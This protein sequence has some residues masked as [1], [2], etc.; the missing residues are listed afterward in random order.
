VRQL[1]RSKDIAPEQVQG[2]IDWKRRNI[3]LMEKTR[4]YM[5]NPPNEA[6][7]LR[8]IIT[9]VYLAY[10]VK[11]A[12]MNASTMMNTYVAAT[13]AA[14]EVQGNKI[15]AR[16]MKDAGWLM[17]APEKYTTIEGVLDSGDARQL[18]LVTIME[19]AIQDGVLDQSYAYYLAG[20]A[21]QNLANA[22]AGKV[23]QGFHKTAEAGMYLFQ[24]MEKANRLVTLLS[25]YEV[26]KL[27]GATPT[28]AYEEA[29]RETNL[30]QNDYSAAN[31]PTLMR[32]KMALF[33][34]FQ[35]Y[36]Q[37]MTWV[38]TGGYERGARA[39]A[40]GAGRSYAPAYRGPTVKL[41]LM[42]LAL[43][44]YMGVPFAANIMDLL[45]VLY[46]KFTGGNL[47]ADV[48]EFFR[49]QSLDSNLVQHGLMHDFF[50]MDL[51][52]SLGLGRLFPGTDM[53]N[54]RS[55]SAPEFF[56]NLG[57]TLLGVFG[58]A[59]KSAW[60]VGYTYVKTENAVEAATKL[61]GAGG[62]V[63]KAM[64]AY[65]RQSLRPDQGRGV[66]ARGD[67]RM[68]LDKETGQYRDLTTWELWAMAA[69]ANPTI[70]SEGMQRHYQSS[71]ERL[72]WEGRKTDLTERHNRAK[73]AGDLDALRAVQADI[74][75]YNKFIPS[76]KL[77]LT[78]SDLAKSFNAHREA[79]KK[80]ERFG[81]TSKK[82]R[83]VVGD[84]REEY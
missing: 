57:L 19:R 1:H 71:A 24:Q 42:F 8:T 10:N 51:S 46:R 52:G 37:F 15:V 40:E 25:M 17:L 70:R 3:A 35:S 78:G 76:H 74:T 75:A 81:T 23:S 49:S 36:A 63:A 30:L 48:R 60:E 64:D 5:L 9:L 16:A 80:T 28:A 41:W 11:T 72:Y 38:M 21:N 58:N 4:E 82:M 26:A 54:K 12:L 47:D 61:P 34:M 2:V 14:G 27:N 29:V 59:G 79:A 7:G 65:L 44:G 68:T 77:R 69:G 32:G 31:R 83:D 66:V 56:G 20:Y 33:T 62:F 53:M 45:Q 39:R 22:M 18:E 6:Q 84:V 73:M 50:G 55:E 43:A 67:A 13:A